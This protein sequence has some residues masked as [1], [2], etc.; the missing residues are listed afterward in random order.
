MKNIIVHLRSLALAEPGSTEERLRLAQQQ[1]GVLLALCGITEPPVPEEII[2][3]LPRLIVHEVASLP[4]PA[5][6][7]FINGSWLMLL[8]GVEPLPWRRWTMMHEFKHILDSPIVER[9]RLS[10]IPAP[11]NRRAEQASEHAADVFA[12]SV[13][14]PSAWVLR[15]WNEGIRE[16][17]L[18]A[19]IF[20]VSFDVMRR[21][22]QE[23]GLVERR[24]RHPRGALI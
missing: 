19:R 1:A 16:I 24:S 10:S 11:A 18:L 7:S 22:L 23:L 17:A 21:R 4:H 12:A 14:M 9:E 8:D 5:E 13:L 2:E 15:V 6:I 3:H 20:G